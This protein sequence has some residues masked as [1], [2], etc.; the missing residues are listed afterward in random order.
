MMKILQHQDETEGEG[1]RGGEEGGSLGVAM[2]AILKISMMWSGSQGM[3]LMDLERKRK[4][5]EDCE[6]SHNA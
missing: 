3:E 4:V 5:A 2:L 1:G 6:P